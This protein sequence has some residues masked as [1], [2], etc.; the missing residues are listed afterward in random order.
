MEPLLY[1]PL[2]GFEW[3][4]AALPA[5]VPYSVAK[6][7]KLAQFRLYYSMPVLPFLFAGAARGLQRA[8]G[9]IRGGGRL[10]VRAGA[11]LLLMTCALDGAGYKFERARP[12]RGEIAPLLA[13]LPVGTPALIQGALLPHAGYSTRFTALDRAARRDGIHAFLLDPPA[14]PYPLSRVELVRLIG[15]LRSDPRYERKASR[16]GRLLCSPYQ[17]DSDAMPQTGIP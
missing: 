15:S 16:E 7:E 3:L 13:A 2:V 17:P 6:H 14:D 5:L 10:P 1:L 9:R 4:L 11:F 8:A 12:E